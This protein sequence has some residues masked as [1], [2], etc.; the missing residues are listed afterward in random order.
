MQYIGYA[1]TSLNAA[2][3]AML[4]AIPAVVLWNLQI[5]LRDKLALAFVLCLSCLACIGVIMKLVYLKAIGKSGDFLC[6]V[7]RSRILAS[8]VTDSTIVQSVPFWTWI[9]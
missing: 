4:T 8:Q 3:D 2:T 7:S 5:N 6:K 1:H 9:T